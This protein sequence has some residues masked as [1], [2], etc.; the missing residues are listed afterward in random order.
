MYDL[1]DILPDYAIVVEWFVALLDFVV[2]KVR[3]GDFDF[4]KVFITFGDFYIRTVT[5]L[6]YCL[7]L[8]FTP[9]I[10]VFYFDDDLLSLAILG[11]DNNFPKP[12][13]SILLALLLLRV[14][15]SA[16]LE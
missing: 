3:E 15:F 5:Y 4:D 8:V 1:F 12:T 14:H 13:D 11:G 16:T 9:F 2:S 10:T 6:P 7:G